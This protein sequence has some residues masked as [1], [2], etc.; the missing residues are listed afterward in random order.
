MTMRAGTVYLVGAGPG[1]PSL[2]TVRGRELLAR[3]DVILHDRLVDTAML[4]FAKLDAELIDVGKSSRGD[5]HL[6]STINAQLVAHAQA[7]RMVV[8]LKGGDPLVFGRG[9]EE[10]QACDDAGV[11]CEMV[12]GISSAL[13][14]PL[15]AG[16]PVTLRGIAATVS[17]AAAPVTDGDR[18]AAVAASDT[19][20]FLMGVREIDSLARRLIAAG[21]NVSTP[22]AVIERAT[23][24][25]ERVVRGSLA[26]IAAIVEHARIESPAVIVVGATAGVTRDLKTHGRSLSGTR[27]VVTR[28]ASAA[29]QLLR[30]LRALGADVLFAPLI[31][32]TPREKICLSEDRLRRA[33]CVA[34]TSRHAVRPFLRAVLQFGDLRDLGH[35]VLAA[36]GPTVAA[37]LSA[38]GL[39]ADLI[40]EVATSES[41]AE[42]ISTRQ[43]SS[44]TGGGVLF[45]AGTLGA[46]RFARALRRR[47]TAVD[48]L[49]VYETRPRTLTDRERAF[50]RE[51]VDAI[52]LASP[53]AA[54]ALSANNLA[55]G[56]AQL[57]CL[58]AETA[59]A[60]V[61]HDAERVHVAPE[62]S[63]DGMIDAVANLVRAR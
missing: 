19:N 61:F 27:V 8:R 7:G 37:E 18:L 42:C 36:I 35:L 46:E 11:P 53:S 3:A 48:T 13:A 12:P 33:S 54:R 60:C 15:A 50:I 55:L 29:P 28:P 57:V 47:G 58:G 4:Q 20:V 1:D 34:F 49:P 22:V 5:T 63:D 2:I 21:K 30:T 10:Q 44:H 25:G 41:L 40:P 51:G 9:W 62:H 45:P 17:I 39:R 6:Q 43:V 23:M 24:P 31:E 59:A 14:A 26:N 52:V 56:T 32:I 16:I 38:W